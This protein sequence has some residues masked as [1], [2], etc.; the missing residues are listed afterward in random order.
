MIPR[1]PHQED[2]IDSWLMSYA[3]MI[4]LLLCFFVIFCSVSEPKKEKLNAITEGMMGK[5]GSVDMA[6]P[7]Q[8]VYRSLQAI[9]ENHQMLRDIA[10]EKGE[11]TLTMELSSLAFYKDKS[12]DFD[13]K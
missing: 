5:F 9:V 8:G 10:I 2:N 1:K 7:F 3:D 11:K 12:A 13:E 6:T 4:T